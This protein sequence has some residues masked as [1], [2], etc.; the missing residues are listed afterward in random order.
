MTYPY[1][2]V[3]KRVELKLF[4]L[5]SPN[6]DADVQLGK[7]E[8]FKKYGTRKLSD[9]NY[10]HI[11]VKVVF[12]SGFRAKTVKAKEGGDSEAFP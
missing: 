7:L 6:L 1:E 2:E 10:F 4:E 8:G 12:Y 11:M 5:R 3:F 9:E